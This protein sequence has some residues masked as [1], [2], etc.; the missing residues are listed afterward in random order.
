MNAFNDLGFPVFDCDNH[1][2]EALDAFTRYL[3]DGGSPRT[4]QWATINGRQY[5]VIGGRVSRVV[6]NATFDPIAK[7]GAMYDYFRGNPDQRFPLD[8]LKDRE[9]IR[10]EYRDRD[11]RLRVMDDQGL[12]QVWMF[13]TLGMLYEELLKHDTPALTQVFTAFNRWV[14]DDWGF[15]HADRIFAAPYIT[16]ADVDHAVAELEYALAR[17]ARVVVMRPAAAFTP[18]GPR[19]PADPEFDPFWARVNE[20]GITVVV[21]A[22]DSG[23]LSNGYAADGFAATFEGA[24]RPSI[25]MLTMERAIYDFL[26]SL[27]FDRLFERFPNVRVA[28]VENGAEF[29]PDLFRKLSSTHKRIPGFFPED[30][31]ETFRRNIWINPFWEDD[32]YVIADMVGEER[33]LFGS[34]WPHIECVPEP[35]SYERELKDF[36]DAARRRILHDNTAELNV[37]RPA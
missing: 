6:T 21:H 4:V 36:S 12:D 34:D 30:P 10:P 26:A 19:T 9:P 18:N 31:I 7:A 2:Y 14:E 17:D 1:Y 15:N 8:F 5:P 23:Y 25:K 16:L 13:P 33:V 28:S 11:A 32:P 22:G 24:E 27:I 37:L 3:P 35:L 29:L 20:S